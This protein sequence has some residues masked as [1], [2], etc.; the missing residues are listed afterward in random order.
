MIK[1]QNILYWDREKTQAGLV[2]DEEAEQHLQAAHIILLLI[3]ADFFAC[4]HCENDK[5]Q[6]LEKHK[7]GNVH[8]I[9]IILR[10]MNLSDTDLAQ[11]PSLPA[12]GKP[13]TNWENRDQAFA[14]IVKEIGEIVQKL[15]DPLLSTTAD[16]SAATMV[17]AKSTYSSQRQRK[18]PPLAPTPGRSLS[19]GTL[20]K[21][22]FTRLALILIPLLIISLL[23]IASAYFKNLHTKITTTIAST[24]ACGNVTG[25]LLCTYRGTGQEVYSV[26]WSPHGNRIVSGGYDNKAAIWDPT[27]GQTYISYAN[28]SEAVAAISWSPDGE[29][30]AS[31]SYDATVQIWDI[32]GATRF[33]Y[34]G[35][36]PYDELYAVAWS[37][38]GKRIASSGQDGTV[39]VWDAATGQ[40]LVTYKGHIS[41]HG[42]KNWVYALAWSPDGQRIASGG[43]DKTVQIWDARSGKTLQIFRK[44]TATIYAVAWS[45]NGKYLASSGGGKVYMWR[46]DGTLVFGSQIAG[47]AISWSPNNQFIVVGDA[48]G[49]VRILRAS[50]GG[51][52]YTYSGHTGRVYAVAWSPEGTRIAS[53][54]SDGTVRIWQVPQL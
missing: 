45:P 51:A 28:H 46:P 2:N 30:L 8:V 7:A 33:T 20:T 54:S 53:G 43:T 44:H 37:P 1:R 6:A 41:A 23:I 22:P 31:A 24:T 21:K 14:D 9:P 38:D 42:T 25:Y 52:A 3:S 29:Y 10:P 13:V 12:N 26:A 16:T 34:R 4:K 15:K 11:L 36:L 47:Y 50:D 49:P 35:H 39:Q 17:A 27:T 5:D 32:T 18:V 40:T 48:D 19:P